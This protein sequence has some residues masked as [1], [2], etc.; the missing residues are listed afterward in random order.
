MN[1]ANDD[2]AHQFAR[3]LV[4]LL[5]DIIVPESL[6]GTI[7]VLEKIRDSP[8]ENVIDRLRDIVYIRTFR[9]PG[10]ENHGRDWLYCAIVPGSGN[11]NGD[12]KQTHEIR[13]ERK[14]FV[15][16]NIPYIS[17]HSKQLDLVCV[18]FNEIH[19]SNRYKFIS[20]CELEWKNG[21][22]NIHLMP[23]YPLNK[24]RF[25]ISGLRGENLMTPVIVLLMI[26]LFRGM[27]FLGV[28]FFAVIIL[29]LLVFIYVFLNF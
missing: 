13:S 10:R 27:N 25:N 26:A 29:L 24:N 6:D 11:V 8:D 4:T 17:W 2:G 7:R 3:R 9:D 14:L 1:C 22:Y 5:K 19:S 20:V 23:H 28:F 15:L 12:F 16:E 18:S 21:K